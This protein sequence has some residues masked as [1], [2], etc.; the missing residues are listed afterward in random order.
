MF[1]GVAI[2]GLAFPDR[3]HSPAEASELAAVGTVTRGIGGELLIP[4][5]DVRL[6]LVGKPA[7][8]M[9]MP[10]AAMHED[11]GPQPCQDDVRSSRKIAA[12][13]AKS[14]AQAMQGGPDRELWARVA[15][16]DTRHVPTAVLWR[17]PIC[18]G[19]SIHADL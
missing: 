2:S 12:M 19:R 8:G 5:S 1:Q 9:L 11:R 13:E 17:E 14:E 10:E 7:P 16:L 15:P 4:E 6:G 3:E 18:H